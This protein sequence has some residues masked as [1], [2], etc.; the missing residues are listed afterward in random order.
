ML[1]PQ[2]LNQIPLSALAAVLI[3]TGFKLAK[4][5]LFRQMWQEGLNQFL[6]FVV[7]VVAIVFTDLL[8]GILVGL[9]F[10]I[11]FILRSNLP[12]IAADSRGSPVWRGLAN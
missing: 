12:A 4:P 6:P 9:A 10:S 5:S 8:I 3:V 11:L 1:F 7:T 2:L